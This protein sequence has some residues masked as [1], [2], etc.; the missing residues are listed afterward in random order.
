MSEPRVSSLEP[1]A[2]CEL[3]LSAFAEGDY[4]RAG[5]HFAH[6]PRELPAA[7]PCAGRMPLRL[8]LARKLDPWLSLIYGACVVLFGV[9]ALRYLGWGL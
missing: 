1:A 4:R 8:F 5:A 6:L 3:G 2:S 7:S 9:V